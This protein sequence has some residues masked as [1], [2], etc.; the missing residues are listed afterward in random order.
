MS[1][2]SGLLPVEQGVACLAALRRHT[3]AV[4]AAGDTRTRDQIMAASGE[5]DTHYEQDAAA[6]EVAHEGA[7]QEATEQE[8][9]QEAS[10]G[11][12]Q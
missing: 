1:V 9:A 4:V 7:A 6:Q 3:D 5:H 11:A 8:V 12:S 2:L 10:E